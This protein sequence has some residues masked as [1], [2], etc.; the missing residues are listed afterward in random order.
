MLI[1]EKDFMKRTIDR[2]MIDQLKEILKEQKR[3]L[4]AKFKK[5][6]E[7]EHKRLDNADDEVE[8]MTIDAYIEV[9]LFGMKLQTV[10]IEKLENK[11]LELYRRVELAEIDEYGY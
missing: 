1:V 5:Q 4:D 3:D 7:L 2:M 9:N 10:I 11:I 6:M 8:L